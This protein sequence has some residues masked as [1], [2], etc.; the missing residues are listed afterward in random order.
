[1]VEGRPLTTVRVLVVDHSAAVWGAER[2]LLDLA[3]LLRARG[4]ELSLASPPGVLARA[5]AE[6]GLPHLPCPPPARGGLR[7]ADGSGRRLPAPELARVAAGVGGAAVRLA[8]QARGF[9]VV[10]SH[11][12]WANVEVVLAGRLARRPTVLDLHDL[13][14]P[15]LGRRLLRWAA[16]SADG[17]VA[18]SRAVA[19]CAGAPAV[20]IT[21][22]HRGVDLDRFVPGPADPAVRRQL[23]GDA[24]APLVGILGRV[25]AEKGIAT[26]ARAVQA[27]DAARLAVVGAPHATGDAEAAAMQ[28]EVT[29]LLGD[30]VRF[31]P[32]RDDVA[33]AM[34]ALDV[35]VNAST[36]EPMGRTVLEAQACGVPVVATAAGGIPEILE[37]GEAGVLVP[38][39]DWQAMSSALGRLLADPELRRRMGAAGRRRMEEAHDWPSRADALAAL[40]R[41][42]AR[43]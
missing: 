6:A 41:R 2:S 33:S 23:A 16:R 11:S 7:R 1:V 15:G 29:A 34:R 8:R 36:A 19:E 21:V 30:R 12:L 39:G 24:E 27:L 35:L 10:Q 14:R 25:D 38:P 43:R 18:V 3:P 4:I 13:V 22:V 31:L 26:V 20:P 28:R 40:Y 5:W 42:V 17:V 32:P 9:D 37:D